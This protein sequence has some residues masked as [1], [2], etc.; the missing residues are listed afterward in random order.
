MII[1]TLI[2]NVLTAI[3]LSG[4]NQSEQQNSDKDAADAIYFGCDII[5]ISVEVVEG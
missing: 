2:T 3:V 5:A 1:R 4:C